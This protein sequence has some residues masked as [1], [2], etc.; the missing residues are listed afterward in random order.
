MTKVILITGASAG[1]GR[2]I[3]EHLAA[4]GH[5]VYGTSRQVQQPTVV[6]GYTMLPLDVQSASSA[7][8]CVQT[9]LDRVGR[10]DVLINNAGYVGPA[11]AIEETS[12]AS[13]R[14]VFE[15]NFWGVVQL[16]NLVL[17]LLRRQGGGHILNISSMGGRIPYPPFFGFYSA[18]KHALEGYTES[19][20]LEV[21]PFNIRVSLI[22][23]GYFKTNIAQTLTPP[24]APLP[25]Y[26]Q[27][28]QH[29]VVFDKFCIEHGRDP[30]Q[31]AAFVARLLTT[32]APLIR[33]PLGF[34]A[35]LLAFMRHW[36]PEKLF[37][38]AMSWFSLQHQPELKATDDE[39]TQA[40]KLGTFR[41]WMFDTSRADWVL[42]RSKRALLGFGLGGLA[43][44]V[45]WFGLRLGRARLPKK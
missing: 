18:S 14:A 41:Y 29:M 31:I 8:A 3:A 10:L 38:K 24:E 32:P 43:A 7:Q 28:R 6:G 36:L 9:I 15:T 23:P 27:R 30:H 44:A 13:A 34:D 2:A 19:L 21:A 37:H 4:Q 33:Y 16:T 17:P 26:D 12:L 11:A 22:E 25:E 40:R 5:V 39:A 42:E 45:V 35:H 20:A 1:I